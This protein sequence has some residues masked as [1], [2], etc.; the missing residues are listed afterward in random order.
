MSDIVEKDSYNRI[1]H[2]KRDNGFEEFTYY[3]DSGS[4]RKIGTHYPAGQ[5]EIERFVDNKD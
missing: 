2:E 3:Y 4:I 1:I 5:V